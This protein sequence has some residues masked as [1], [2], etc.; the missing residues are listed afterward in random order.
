MV[1]HVASSTSM[2][3]LT[4]DENTPQKKIHLRNKVRK[5]VESIYFKCFDIQKV[6][7]TIEQTNKQMNEPTNQ[8]VKHAQCF[9]Y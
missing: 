8:I 7:R 2:N 9:C 1:S 3:I 5:S 6:N 4:P